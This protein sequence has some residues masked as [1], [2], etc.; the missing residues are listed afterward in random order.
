MPIPPPL[1]RWG[2][3][4]RV[5]EDWEVKKA[6][7]QAEH[8]LCLRSASDMVIMAE[9]TELMEALVSILLLFRL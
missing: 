1:Q 3:L 5:G 2:I 4:G 8:A 6:F 9:R 7:V